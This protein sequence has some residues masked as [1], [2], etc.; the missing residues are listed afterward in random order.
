MARIALGE[1]DLDRVLWIPTGSPGY[2]KPPVASPAHRIAMLKLAFGDE[3]RYAIDERELSPHASGY[4]V[5]TLREL[6][7]ELGPDNALF[8]LLGGDQ[9]AAF[10]QWREPEEVARLATPVV[11]ARPGF[12]VQGEAVKTV[13]MPLMAVSASDIRA[14]VARGESIAALVPPAVAAHIERHGLYR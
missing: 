9:Y 1:L 5:D 6:R 14:R 4:T 12:P 11:F 8:L 13:C 2:R 10:A 7:R 3:A